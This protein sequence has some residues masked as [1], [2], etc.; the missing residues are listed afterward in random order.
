MNYHDKYLKY[1]E[2]YI[3]LKKLLGCDV[4]EDIIKDLSDEDI[5][6]LPDE[7]FKL[8]KELYPECE[9]DFENLEEIY[10]DHE[11]TY[12]ELEYDG[13]ET[14]LDHLDIKFNNFIDLGSGRGRLP[15]YLAGH[16][17]ILKS[18]GIELVKE[19]HYYASE[20]KQK[21]SKFSD[22]TNKVIFIND[23][24][25]NVNLSKYT[26]GLTLV[27]INNL[28]FNDEFNNKIFNNLLNVL[29][30]GSVIGCSKQFSQGSNIMDSL[31]VRMSWD[32]NVDIFL[33]LI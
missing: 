2:K 33:Y 19:R 28:F 15:L 22:Q 6:F 29:P 1:K 17:N 30:S 12:G 26:N 14:I 9:Y 5:V 11:I 18:V 3:N 25:F 21:L 24:F 13:I 20:L 7:Y 23:D 32:K 27:W 16:P 4:R 10:K 8:L 31:S